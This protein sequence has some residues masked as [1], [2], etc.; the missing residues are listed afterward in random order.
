MTPFVKLRNRFH[1]P[2]S[3]KQTLKEKESRKIRFPLYP[4]NLE[5][6]MRNAIAVSFLFFLLSGCSSI[7]DSRTQEITVSTDPAGAN[8]KLLRSGTI[9]GQIDQTPG[10]ITVRKSTYDLVVVCTLDGYLPASRINEADVSSESVVSS[11]IGG[12]IGWAIDSTTGTAN[13]Y[14]GTVTIKMTA[15]PK[16]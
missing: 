10:K 11:I 4:A 7:L 9:I 3:S 1:L 6:L 5:F 2:L 12:G 16:G 15:N 14:D 8:C 13:Q